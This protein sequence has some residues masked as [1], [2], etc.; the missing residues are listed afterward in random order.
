MPTKTKPVEP[1]TPAK[2]KRVKSTS[3]SVETKRAKRTAVRPAPVKVERARNA[4]PASPSARSERFREK[5][6]RDEESIPEAAPES[7]PSVSRVR[8]V[9]WIAVV[10]VLAFVMGFGGGYWTWGRDETAE[11]K[12]RT[13]TT[14]LV[15]QINPKDGYA[16][17]VSYGD[18]APRMIEAG[19]IDYDNFM[20][21]LSRSGDAISNVQIDIM[22]QGSD[23]QIVIT[24]ENAHFLLNYFWAVG[25]ANRNTIL[26]EGAMVK[27]GEGNVEGFAS[28]G[29]WTLAAKP[30]SEIYA[31]MDLIPLTAEQQARVEEVAA[32][33]YRPC[34]NNPTLFPDCNHGMAML[35]LLEL[36]AANGATVDEMFE[37]AKYVNAFWFPQQNLEIAMFLDTNQNMD[38][39]DAD[40]RMIVGAQF[41][42][43]SGFAVV[44]QQLQAAGLL[45]QAPRQ[46]GSCGS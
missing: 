7:R 19:V 21:A 26:T 24:R 2:T 29:G 41:S 20:A 36:M 11:W 1:V 9:A 8:Q 12:Q 40:P 27:Y 3:A 31:S 30:I 34:C 35:G 6:K 4:A 17:P 44:H 39:K 13:E 5:I 37:A 43:G 25:L 16:L 15:E 45:P 32:A 33:V 28:T 42:S 46:G 14:A 18:L 10:A 38:F 22:K 23:E